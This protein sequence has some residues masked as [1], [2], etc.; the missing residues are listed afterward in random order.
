MYTQIVTMGGHFLCFNPLPFL[1]DAY[2]ISL[3]PLKVSG[4]YG[5]VPNKNITARVDD[6]AHPC[7][8]FTRGFRR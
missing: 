8:N 4:V 2:L 6:S 3:Y 5:I 7:K 1:A